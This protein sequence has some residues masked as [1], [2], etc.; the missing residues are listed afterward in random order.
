LKKA[1]KK[2]GRPLLKN[3]SAASWSFPLL[4]KK[5][6]YPPIKWRGTIK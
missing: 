2:K 5:Q 6:K 4:H 1:K 3:W